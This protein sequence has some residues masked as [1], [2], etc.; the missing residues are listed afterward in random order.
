MSEPFQ[1]M[2]LSLRDLAAR[3]NLNL[4]WKSVFWCN[5]DCQLVNIDTGLNGIAGK[6]PGRFQDQFFTR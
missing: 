1:F 6:S 5:I 3:S 4:L 2:L